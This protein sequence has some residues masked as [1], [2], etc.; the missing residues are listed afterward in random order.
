[1]A[2]IITIQVS[3]RN[4]QLKKL[5]WLVIA[6]QTATLDAVVKQDGIS[7]QLLHQVYQMCLIYKHQV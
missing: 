7:V 6:M 4:I 3:L 5:E 2:Y 1:M